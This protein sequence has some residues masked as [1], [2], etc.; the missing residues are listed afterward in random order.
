MANRQQRQRKDTTLEDQADA[1][2]IF[3]SRLMN[4]MGLPSYRIHIMEEP[5]DDEA[6][7]EIKCIEDRYVAELYLC[8][9][10][11]ERRDEERRDTITHEVL[12]LW[13]RP[14]TD[15][16]PEPETRVAAAGETGSE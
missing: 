1:L 5:A 14:L 9:E 15:W 12:H 16:F 4:A 2:L 6:I 10:W 13:H 3:M 11:L 7:A 8:Q